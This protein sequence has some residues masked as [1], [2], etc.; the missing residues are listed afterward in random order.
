MFCVDNIGRICI[1]ISLLGL[2][3]LKS[4]RKLKRPDPKGLIIPGR[5]RGGGGVLPYSL[6][7]G[8]LLGSR[9]SYPLLGQILQIL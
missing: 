7:G 6:G 5:E 8:V 2:K 1:L 3:G 4:L 9:K